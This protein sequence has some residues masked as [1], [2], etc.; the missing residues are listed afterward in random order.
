LTS[1]RRAFLAGLPLAACRPPGPRRPAL[2]SRELAIYT[3]AGYLP[4]SVVAAFE[5]RTGVRATVATYEN[6]EELMAALATRPTTYDVVFPSDYAVD[7]L[8]RGRALRALEFDRIPNHVNIAPQLISPYY[9]PGTPGQQPKYSLPYLWG[10]T[11][12]AY[13][14]T[15][16]VEAPRRWVDLWRPEFAGK[17]VLLD[18]ARE[19]I[20]IGLVALGYRKNSVRPDEIAAARDKL[21]E[22][23]PHVVAFDANQGEDPLI[24][25]DAVV[26]ALFSG[27]AAAAQARS[28]NIVWR[29]PEEGAG[30]WFDNVAI[31]LLAPHADAGQ[32]FV[33]FLLDGEQGAAVAAEHPFSVANNAALEWWR[34]HD[35]ARYKR[36]TESNTTNP[37][38]ADVARAVPVKNVGPEASALYDAAWEAV[39]A[40]R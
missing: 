11:G 5:K 37:S 7:I 26:G 31:P 39:K 8:I 3:F 22:L 2:T 12:I 14:R 40:A 29:L 15:R 1:S 36:Y 27:N 19:M 20:G 25:G 33:D 30:I 16:V 21:K 9:D 4:P 23:A 35:A 28:P 18:D 24:A 10:T 17:L 32:A 6:N 34:V 38:A 13:D